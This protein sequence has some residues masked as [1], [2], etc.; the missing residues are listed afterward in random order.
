LPWVSASGSW[1]NSSGRHFRTDRGSLLGSSLSSST[2]ARAGRPERPH[3]KERQGR[4]AF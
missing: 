4:Q 3:R 2:V 1:R